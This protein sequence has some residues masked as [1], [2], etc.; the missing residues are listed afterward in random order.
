MTAP[1]RAQGRSPAPDAPGSHAARKKKLLVVAVTLSC[2][3]SAV[4]IWRFRVHDGDERRGR[5]VDPEHLGADLE[6]MAE[7][8]ESFI[9]FWSTFRYDD[10]LDVSTGETRR[11]VVLAIEKEKQLSA[12]ERQVAEDLRRNV[13]ELR[14]RLDVTEV[15]D[16]DVDRQILRGVATASAAD[17]QFRR[18]QEFVMVRVEGQ[19]KVGA[20]DPGETEGPPEGAAEP[21]LQDIEP[22]GPSP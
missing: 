21:G 1:R 6:D 7:V 22:E 13:E 10:A 2:V 18:H 3:A 14:V 19:W 11:R 16:D 15:I 9:N 5:A 4:A 12:A 8:A 17:R 20:W